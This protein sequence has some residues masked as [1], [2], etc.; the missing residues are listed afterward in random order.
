MP[1]R[2]R[3]KANVEWPV[4]GGNECSRTIRSMGFAA[5]PCGNGYAYDCQVCSKAKAAPLTEPRS[6]GQRNG[7]RNGDRDPTCATASV[8]A[9]ASSG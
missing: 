4:S 3:T 8:R 5:T 1:Y 2:G 7:L 6:G 9:A